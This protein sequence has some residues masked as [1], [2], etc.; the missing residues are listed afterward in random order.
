M[1][2][3]I[4]APKNPTGLYFAREARGMSQDDLAAASK[5]N[6]AQISKLENGQRKLTKEWAILFG[7]HLGYHP[8]EI[9]FW[10]ELDG[11][12]AR[13]LSGSPNGKVIPYSIVSRVGAG[14]WREIENY[15]TPIGKYYATAHP[16]YPVAKQ[17]AFEVEGD[18]MDL[19][20]MPNGTILLAV[21]FYNSGIQP[22]DGMIVIVEERRDDG[23]IRRRTVKELHT[24]KDHF[25]LRPRSSNPAHKTLKIPKKNPGDQKKEIVILAAVTDIRRNIIPPKKRGKPR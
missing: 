19:A 4:A 11:T 10:G 7:K 5:E 21:E 16:D 23:Q 1:A 8:V 12:T 9:M 2:R 6:K 24:M 13:E 17:V 18:S 20:G 15:E 22:Y 14:D 25:E 3:R